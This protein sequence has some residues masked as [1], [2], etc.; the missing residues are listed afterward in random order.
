MVGDK[1]WATGVKVKWNEYSNQWSAAVE[2]YDSGFCQD[3]STEG[4][5]HTRY[6][7]DD[8]NDAIRVVMEDAKKLGIVFNVLTDAVPRLYFAGDGE[9]EENPPPQN[10]RHLIF[11]TAERHGLKSAYDSDAQAALDAAGG[12]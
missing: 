10:W 3:D 6:Y 9:W 4:E 5:I 7:C 8:I 1:F 12:Q 2:F 11:E